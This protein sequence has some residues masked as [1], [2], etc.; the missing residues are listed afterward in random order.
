M[1]EFLTLN[2]SWQT[3]VN[4]KSHNNKVS[5]QDQ[6][7]YMKK[8]KKERNYFRKSL[9]FPSDHPGCLPLYAGFIFQRKI[10]IDITLR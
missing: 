2:N 1:K 8:L 6:Y 3:P 4:F 9:F 5:S 7:F 10:A